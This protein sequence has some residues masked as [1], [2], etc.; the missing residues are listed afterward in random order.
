MS[1]K[2]LDRIRMSSLR[3]DDIKNIFEK[4]L[5]N[6]LDNQEFNI[7]EKNKSP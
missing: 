1:G 6:A 2:I 4:E 5:S 3:K 7:N